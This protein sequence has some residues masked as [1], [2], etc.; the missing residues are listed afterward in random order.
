MQITSMQKR[1][2]LEIN[3]SHQH[4]SISLPLRRKLEPGSGTYMGCDDDNVKSH[5]YYIPC[6]EVLRTRPHKIPSF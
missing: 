1:G 5:V 2:K 4:G 3:P 6:V